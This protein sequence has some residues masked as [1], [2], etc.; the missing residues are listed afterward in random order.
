MS[1]KQLPPPWDVS[2]QDTVLFPFKLNSAHRFL[3]AWQRLVDLK[4]L[5][6]TGKGCDDQDG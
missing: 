2:S 5:N 3:L 6:P 1:G 4:E